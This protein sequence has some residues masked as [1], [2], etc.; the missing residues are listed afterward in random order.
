MS[1]LDLV[2]YSSSEPLDSPLQHF[3]HWVNVT[4]DHT[5]VSCA[6]VSLSFRQLD[7]LSDIF[8]ELLTNNGFLP[9]EPL[10]IASKTSAMSLVAIMAAWKARGHYIPLHHEIPHSRLDSILART[11]ARFAVVDRSRVIHGVHCFAVDEIAFLKES[12]EV[13]ALFAKEQQNHQ[14]PDFISYTIFTSG[15]TGVPKGVTILNNNLSHFILWCQQ[16]LDF[17]EG[18][19]VLNIADLSFDQS[20]MDI[21]FMLAFGCELHLFS[22][23]KDPRH[24]S[25]YIQDHGIE[26]VSSVPTTFGMIFDSRFGIDSDKLAS[27]SHIFVGGAA[28]PSSYVRQFG[29]K[30]PNASVYNMYGPT[31][32]TVYCM[33]YQFTE[34]DL[35]NGVDRVPLGKVFTGH[36]IRVDADEG[37]PERGELTVFGP[38]VMHSYWGEPD[39]TEAVLV[40]DSATGFRGYKTGDIVE[41]GENGQYYFIG[42]VNDTIKSGGYRI[43]LGDIESALLAIPQI[44][45]AAVV[46]MA[47]TLLEN[48]LYAFVQLAKKHK[49]D[50]PSHSLVFSGLKETLPAYMIPHE[51]SFIDEMPLNT[52]GKID[53]KALGKTIGE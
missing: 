39:K 49:G 23:M 15:S 7:K 14:S 8:C 22:H 34:D 2:T 3:L 46:A 28:C 18:K 20:V 30:V 36:G 29:E 12:Y 4:P 45:Q 33:A 40:T 26:V 9:G 42:R 25:Q 19:K 43:D 10:L 38:Q 1:Q 52:S 41:R 21:V 35:Q 50:D 37:N 51:I 48:K 17:Q 27:L 24:I 47:D 16:Y 5:A 53:K 44:S 31:E 11:H 6:G 13:P 32:V